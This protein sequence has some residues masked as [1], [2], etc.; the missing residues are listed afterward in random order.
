[1]TGVYAVLI[2]IA[3]CAILVIVICVLAK[4]N[5]KAK[6][7]AAALHEAL[8]QVKDRAERLQKANRNTAKV[9]ENANAQRQELNS[10]PDAGLVNRANSLFNMHDNEKRQ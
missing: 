5:R 8:S 6:Q 4:R 1:M 9:E 7:E 2:L 10:T 3:I